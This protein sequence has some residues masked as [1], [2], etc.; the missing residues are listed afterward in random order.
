[1]RPKAAWGGPTLNFQAWRLPCADV[2]RMHLIETDSGRVVPV[3]AVNLDEG[4]PERH[5]EIGARAATGGMD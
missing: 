5:P 4:D 1:M 2:E 3:E